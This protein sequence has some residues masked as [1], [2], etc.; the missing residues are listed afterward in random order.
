MIKTIPLDIFL[1]LIVGLVFALSA[2]PLL[3]KEESMINTYFI[4]ALMFQ[5]L[6]FLPIGLF[7]AWKWTAWSWMYLVEPHSHGKFWTWLAVLSYV[8]AMIA[9]FHIAYMCIRAGKKGQANWYLAVAS[10]AI[11]LITVGMFGRLYHVSNNYLPPSRIIEAPGW[12]GNGWFM[13]SMLVITVVFVGGLSYVL[14][15]NAA[16]RGRTAKE[17]FSSPAE[18]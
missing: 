9:G 8:P 10:L 18:S 14:R 3:E 2:A 17:A 13:L 11:V 12:F 6:I 4:R 7:L 15:L 16:D 1:S 5:V